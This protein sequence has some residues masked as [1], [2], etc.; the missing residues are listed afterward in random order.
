MR[1]RLKPATLTCVSLRILIVDD[2]APFLDAARAL[3]ERESLNVVGEASNVAEALRKA[4]E[5]GPDV[6]LVDVALGHESGLDLARRLA[7]HGRPGP[8]ILIST[9]AEED[10]ADLIVQCPALG[11]IPKSDLSAA[12]IHGVLEAAQR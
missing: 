12:A 8:V 7:A 1:H 11:F 6:I 10:L 3:L 9:R 2:S 5:L 4:E